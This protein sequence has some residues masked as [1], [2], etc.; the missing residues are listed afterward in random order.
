MENISPSTVRRAV[1]GPLGGIFW[2]QIAMK[3]VKN[4]TVPT[5][6]LVS[7]HCVLA[8]DSRL[9]PLNYM[10]HLQYT[11]RVTSQLKIR[12]ISRTTVISI[13]YKIFKF[14]Q[15]TYR[16]TTQ[17]KP[18]NFSHLHSPLVQKKLAVTYSQWLH[19][20]T[21]VSRWP[22]DSPRHRVSITER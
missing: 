22:D 17:P 2:K 12:E 9:V 3:S 14:K 4:I 8:F 16:N 18:R 21:Y 5:S 10:T 6:Y 15:R 7:R 13:Y 1:N 19:I 11:S 20:Y